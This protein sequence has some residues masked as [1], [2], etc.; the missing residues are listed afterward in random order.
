MLTLLLSCQNEKEKVEETEYGESEEQ[1]PD[2][3]LVGMYNN[4]FNQRGRGQFAGARG[5]GQ[6]G[7]QRGTGQQG[8]Q[9]GG[10]RYNNQNQRGS[11]NQR[12]GY[13]GN[14]SSSATRGSQGGGG[15]FNNSQRGR[16]GPF[17]RGAG[18]AGVQGGRGRSQFGGDVNQQYEE[19]EDQEYGQ[20]THQSFANNRG[21]GVRGRGHFGAQ[22]GGR[23]Y[24]PPLFERYDEQIENYS[25][26]GL[27]EEYEQEREEQYDQKQTETGQ[28]QQSRP[29]EQPQQLYGREDSYAHPEPRPSDKDRYDDRFLDRERYPLDRYADVSTKC[30]TA[31]FLYNDFS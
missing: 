11:G 5:R 16:G 22:R 4:Q 30:N 28:L 18:Q 19:T 10:G 13:F 6:I 24:P 14:Q 15:L 3:Q 25:G 2:T 8:N 17:V 23:P 29:E 1:Y 7:S 20:E 12:A 21:H 27:E 31:S 26:Q 9:R